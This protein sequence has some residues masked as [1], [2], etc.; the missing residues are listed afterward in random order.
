MG[1][2]DNVKEGAGYE[3][4]DLSKHEDKNSILDNVP[5]VGGKDILRTLVEDGI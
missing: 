4:G 2:G 3:P 5:V 1:V